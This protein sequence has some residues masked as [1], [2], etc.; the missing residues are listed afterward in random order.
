MYSIG[1]K[2]NVFLKVIYNPQVTVC[3]FTCRKINKIQ[4]IAKLG[5]VIHSGPSHH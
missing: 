5:R 3:G 4:N 1:G 2:S